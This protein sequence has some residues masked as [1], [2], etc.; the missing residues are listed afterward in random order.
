V[1]YQQPPHEPPPLVVPVAPSGREKKI[2]DIIDPRTGVN[3]IT[4]LHE[5]SSAEWKLLAHEV[6]HYTLKVDLYHLI[7]LLSYCP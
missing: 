7:N 5:S 6:S 4:A 3:V 2:I 1:Y